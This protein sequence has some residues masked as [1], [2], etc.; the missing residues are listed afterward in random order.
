MQFI[1]HAAGW[2]ALGSNCHGSKS[3]H[4]HLFP[5]SDRLCTCTCCPL[6]P[7]L[8]VQAAAGFSMEGWQP[9][10][11]PH[12]Q[13]YQAVLELVG[14]HNWTAVEQ[15]TVLKFKARLGEWGVLSSN[16]GQHEGVLCC[17]CCPVWLSTSC[18]HGPREDAA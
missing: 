16:S 9:A 12:M 6:W 11:A 17:A 7:V 2:P 5:S 15:E 8:Q 10:P 4:I 18:G 3:I 13:M 1:E 14:R